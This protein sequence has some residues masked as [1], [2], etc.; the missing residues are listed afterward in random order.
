MHFTKGH[1][2]I[3]NFT[4]FTMC[5]FHIQQCEKKMWKFNNVFLDVFCVD[6][7][8]LLC[9]VISF[10]DTRCTFET[11]W[12]GIFSLNPDEGFAWSDGS[13]VSTLIFHHICLLKILW[14]LYV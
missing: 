13:P 5:S 6:V 3:C 1:R 14:D 2:E 7:Y 8:T 11:V 10:S 9:P 4:A 12:L